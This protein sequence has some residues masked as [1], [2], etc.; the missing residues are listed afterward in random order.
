MWPPQQARL[1][2]SCTTPARDGP[3]SHPARAHQLTPMS[4][5]QDLALRRPRRPSLVSVLGASP[6]RV[7]AE[8]PDGLRLHSAARAAWDHTQTMSQGSGAVFPLPCKQRAT[9]GG[10]AGPAGHVQADLRAP[11]ASR[12]LSLGSPSNLFSKHSSH[13]QNTPPRPRPTGPHLPGLP[14]GHRPLLHQPRTA[15]AGAGGVGL[16]AVRRRPPVQRRR[17]VGRWHRQGAR[18]T[19]SRAQALGEGPTCR[20]PSG[21]LGGQLH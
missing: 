21:L 3:S 14:L 1:T 10:C 9:P 2:A 6:E 15:G 13:S 17:L 11:R 16:G 5:T 8:V 18:G 7:T 12:T 4:Q 20:A 19:A